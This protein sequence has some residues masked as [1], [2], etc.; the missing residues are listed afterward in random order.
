MRSKYN[1]P[2]LYIED[3]I[4][5]EGVPPQPFI[6]W[7]GGKTQ[8]LRDLKNH[9]PD[10]KTTLNHNYFEP[11]VGGGAVFFWCKPEQAFLSD[12]NRDLINAY[13]VIRDNV[14]ILMSELDTFS[15]KSLSKET[16]NT[17]RERYRQLVHDRDEKD[18]ILRAALLIFLNKTCYNGLYRVNQ[19]GAFNVPFGHYLRPPSLYSRENLLSVSEHLQKANIRCAPYDWI[20]DEAEKGDFIYFDPPYDSP[21]PRNGFT[22][23]NKNSFLRD[24]HNHLFEVFR[25]LDDRGCYIMLS[26]AKTEFIEELYS[27]YEHYTHV[28]E[29][30][31][32]INCKGSERVNF[33][34]LLILNYNSAN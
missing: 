28:L 1:L 11:F 12:C 23:Y 15:K 4:S 25:K 3:E 33:E 13:R 16:Y 24:E 31:R 9:F 2:R 26:N 19:K 14:S 20:L 8:I 7:A 21:S 10:H 22:S 34:E 29:A 32:M 6:K 17:N 30:H 27:D 5:L 18:D